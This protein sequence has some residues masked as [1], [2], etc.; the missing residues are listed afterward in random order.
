MDSRIEF[1]MAR[2]AEPRLVEYGWVVAIGVVTGL[3]GVLYNAAV[4]FALRRADASRLPR[5]VRA[6][7]TG[8]LV[9]LLVWAAPDLAE[10]GRAH[11]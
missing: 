4:M 7:A 5:E 9:G 8:A 2:L 11:V 3:L 6:A 1:H 10:I